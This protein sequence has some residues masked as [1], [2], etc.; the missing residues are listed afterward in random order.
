MI[1]LIS[2]C[3]QSES[4]AENTNARPE[5][6]DA[7]Q[8]TETSFPEKEI[9]LVAPFPAGGG[10]DTAART[11][12]EFLGK[13]LGESVLVLNAPGAGGVT[14]TK[15]FAREKADGYTLQFS[16][17]SLFTTQPHLHDDLG[18]S[19]E[20]F[21]FLIGPASAYPV[22]SVRADSPYQTLSDLIEDAKQNNKRI[23]F[24]HPGVGS[25]LQNVGLSL[26]EQ[27]GIEYQDIPFEGGAQQVVAILGGEIDANVTPEAT[28]MSQIQEGTIRALAV[29]S[30]ERSPFLPDVPTM[31]EEGY[32]V[33]FSTL[34]SV[35][36]P[37]GIPEDVK[38]V[39][40]D[41]L[42]KMVADPEYKEAMEKLGLN[43]ENKSGEEVVNYIKSA[44]SKYEQVIKKN[45]S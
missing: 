2:G 13:H 14:Q 9:T 44:L 21:E 19:H 18:Y 10:T 5:S 34:Y 8:P 45:Q 4:P 42:N 6:P 24:G 3:G 26:F 35:Y 38:Q 43:T 1:L 33:E 16:A 23:T 32:D 28:I 27:A 41:A 31:K 17:D 39:L 7:G 11:V 20:D 25:S 15:K 12:A 36:A 37:K 22:L 29:G 40:I 30:P